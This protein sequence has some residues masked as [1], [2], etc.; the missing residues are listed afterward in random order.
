MKKVLM[1][2]GLLFVTLG[3]ALG[4]ALPNYAGT[5]ALDKGKSKDLPPMM[6]NMDNFELTVTQ[7]DKQLKVKASTGSDEIAYNLDGS[8]SKVQVTGR[9]PGEATVYLE[10]KDDGKLVLHTERELNFQGNAVSI[11]VTENWELADEGKSLNVK[12]TIESPRGTQEMTM[13]FTKKS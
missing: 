2:S 4:A 10:K 9:M 6:A 3:L 12:R 5:W 7:D 1:A 11:K 13:V 8:K